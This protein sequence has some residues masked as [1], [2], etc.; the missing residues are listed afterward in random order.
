MRRCPLHVARRSMQ[1]WTGFARIASCVV[2]VAM[3][4]LA[5][6]ARADDSSQSGVEQVTVKGSAVGGFSTKR[7]LDDASREVTDAASLVEAAPGVHV[8]RL[9]ADDSFA[10]LSIRGT[11]S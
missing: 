2:I 9:G 8:R 10:S 1:G 6:D 3:Q 5:N 7:S 4:A 11:S